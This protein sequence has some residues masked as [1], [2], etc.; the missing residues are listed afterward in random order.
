MRHPSVYGNISDDGSPQPNEFDISNVVKNNYILF[1]SPNEF[2]VFMLLPVNNVTYDL[3]TCI[4][5][6]G[7]GKLAF[8]AV[9]QMLSYVF[10]NTKC[11][12]IIGKVPEYNKP[13][14]AFILRSGFKKEGYSDKSYLK[15]GFLYGQ[16]FVGINKEEFLKCQ[17]SQQ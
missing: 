10:E 17:Q 4:L 1:I 2:T 3:H 8:K 12:K 15:D 9:K 7:R 14:M 11:Q 6:Q 5:P 13:A 16:Y